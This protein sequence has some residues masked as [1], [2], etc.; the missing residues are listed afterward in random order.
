MSKA[1]GGYLRGPWWRYL[2][3]DTAKT[4]RCFVI[5]WGEIIKEPIENFR[6]DVHSVQFAIRTGRG[7]G[8]NE[9][10]LYCV[11]Y[12]NT[13]VSLIAKAMERHDVV[14]LCGIWTERKYKTKKGDSMSYEC[15][16][17]FIIPQGLV[18]FLLDMYSSGKVQNMM[19]EYYNEDADVW[20]SDDD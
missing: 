5:A 8:R 1:F 17:G 2:S 12:G 11:A 9:K 6:N 4:R 14:L 3:D 18:A 13:F 10:S 15:K 20:E 16:V 19:D 7:E